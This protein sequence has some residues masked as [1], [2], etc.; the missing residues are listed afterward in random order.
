MTEATDRLDRHHQLSSVRLSRTA[1]QACRDDVSV[2]CSQ[3][4]T[5]SAPLNPTHS[6]ARAA[7]EHPQ[8]TTQGTRKGQPKAA[9]KQ[10]V[11]PGVSAR[12]FHRKVTG[13]SRA[14][15]NGFP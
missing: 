1:G 3:R 13:F 6:V 4:W 7:L 9:L 10:R 5:S 15:I 2:T 11:G 12:L 8:R 14:Q